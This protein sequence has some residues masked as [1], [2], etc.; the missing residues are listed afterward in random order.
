M[1]VLRDLLP[2]IRVYEYIHKKYDIKV[3]SIV[4]NNSF[5]IHN[6]DTSCNSVLICRDKNNKRRLILIDNDKLESIMKGIKE[7]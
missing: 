3:I 6:K 7:L 2:R 4:D 1:N 5:F